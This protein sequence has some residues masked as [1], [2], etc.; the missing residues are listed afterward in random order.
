M[1]DEKAGI[2]VIY[3]GNGRFIQGIPARDLTDDVWAG[4]TA[5][6][7]AAVD[8]SELYEIVPSEKK[9]SAKKGAERVK[10]DGA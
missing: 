5:A 1:K 7:Q 4:L 6:Q 2:A 8:S 9:T 3:V 10:K